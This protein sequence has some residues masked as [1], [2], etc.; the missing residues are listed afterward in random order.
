MSDTYL[1]ATR[2]QEFPLLLYCQVIRSRDWD[3]AIVRKASTHTLHMGGP[4]SAAD[5][6]VPAG[7]S[8][9]WW[10]AE[11]S[12]DTSTLVHKLNIKGEK[13]SRD[14]IIYILLSVVLTILWAGF[15]Y[16]CT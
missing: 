9:S 11:N 16:S 10:C 12:P 5:T 4:V 3:N 7:Q 1:V 8:Y 6:T 15:I 14:C 2:S 13:N